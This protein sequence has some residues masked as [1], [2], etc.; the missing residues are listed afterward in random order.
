MPREL[1]APLSTEEV[2]AIYDRIGRRYDL[3]RFA[4]RAPN[5]WALARLAVQPGE[6]VLEAGV[7]TGAVFVELAR[8]AA[9]TARPIGEPN[10]SGLD[11]SPEMLAVTRERIYAAH[12][13]GVTDVRRGDVR[14]L[15]YA[16]DSFD[17]VFCSYMLDLLP[18]SA[19]AVALAELRRVLRPGG[20]L[21]LVALS[22]GNTPFARAFTAA[23]ETLYRRRPNWLAGCRP[24]ELAA[25]VTA[26]GFTIAARREWFRGHPS[27]AVL[28]LNPLAGQ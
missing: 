21:A 3:L 16:D 19:I 24:I 7:G 10:V 14:A 20:R 22:P 28:A 27:E 15:P 5:R 11:A 4:E 26:A 9:P 25:Y 23:Y 1:D 8:A 2:R 13:D 6:R 12:L 17:V 18:S